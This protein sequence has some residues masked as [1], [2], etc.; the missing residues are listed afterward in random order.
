MLP[1]AGAVIRRALHENMEIRKR[2]CGRY[3]AAARAGFSAETM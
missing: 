1:P 3:S 2:V